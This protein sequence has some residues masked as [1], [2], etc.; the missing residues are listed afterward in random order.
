MLICQKL[1]SFKE[2]DPMPS[3]QESDKQGEILEFKQ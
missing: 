2:G 3:L 1:R